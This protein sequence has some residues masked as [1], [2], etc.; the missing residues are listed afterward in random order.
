MQTAQHLPR[1]HQEPRRHY[2]IPDTQ[3]RPG[4]PIDHLEWVARDIV[5]RKPDV[6]VCLGDWY[7]LPSLSRYAPAGGTEKEGARLKADLDAGHA[8]MEV[9]TGPIHEEIARTRRRHLT[10][11][12]PRMIFC[13][14]NHEA[15]A[16]RFAKEDAR[17]EGLIGTHL[18]E[19]ERFGWERHKFLKPVEIDG[20][21]Y[22]HYWQSGHSDRPIGGSIENRLNKLGFSF[23]AGHEQGRRYSDRPLPNGKTIH[24]IVVGSF[25]LGAE[26]YRG[27]QAV[28]EWRGTV[29]LHDVQDGDCDPMFL[30]L[31]YLCRQYAG[32]ELYDYMT[33]RYPD[34]R[35][36]HLR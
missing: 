6:I 31:A 35:W 1:K 7:D 36:E 12:N 24:G 3:V 14:G 18:C 27:P 30:R 29:V 28:N 34:G 16:A 15:R 2:I 19:V 9:L 10:R 5:R 11:W 21:W 4:D 20:V 23:V 33:E 13:E 17:F 26:A 8:A 25:Y 32:M 22:A